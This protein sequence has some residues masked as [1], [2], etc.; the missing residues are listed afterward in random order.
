[1]LS[2][3][4]IWNAQIFKKFEKFKVWKFSHLKKSAIT[5]AQGCTYTRIQGFYYRFM[6]DGSCKR[7]SGQIHHT[8]SSR[9]T[10]WQC[11]DMTKGQH[12]QHIPQI[13]IYSIIYHV[14]ICM[15]SS[16]IAER[17]IFC[18]HISTG[19]HYKVMVDSRRLTWPMSVILTYRFGC[20]YASAFRGRRHYVFGLSVRPSVS[21]SEA[22]NTLFWPVHGSVGPADQ[23]F[24]SIS[25]RPS[26]RRGFRAFAGE[27]ME[28]IAWNF[29]CWCI[30]TIFRTVKFMVMVC[31][32]F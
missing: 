16:C 19:F 4:S 29:T 15:P 6:T 21:P 31:W 30:L 8:S 20:F 23:P 22:W 14:Y 18:I 12:S 10:Q 17:L 13:Y 32:F 26:V 3:T 5:F 2:N 27:R 24:Y 28:G 9:P 1:M 25:V 7:P 11:N